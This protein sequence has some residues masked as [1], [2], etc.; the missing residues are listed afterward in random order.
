M[1]P[2]WN[3]TYGSPSRRE[4]ETRLAKE[5]STT[6]L[7]KHLLA[8]AALS[9]GARSEG[10]FVKEQLTKGIRLAAP[11]T[12]GEMA[13]VLPR[14]S[15]HVP[16]EDRQLEDIL[17]AVAKAPKLKTPDI[18]SGRSMIVESKRAPRFE[19]PKAADAVPTTPLSPKRETPTP[20]PSLPVVNALDGYNA[21]AEGTEDKRSIWINKSEHI[22]V[23]AP[24]RELAASGS[25]NPELDVELVRMGDGMFVIV[26]EGTRSLLF[27]VFRVRGN[28]RMILS[29]CF[30]VNS[31]GIDAVAAVRVSKVSQAAVCDATDGRW[32]LRDKGEITV[33]VSLEAGSAAGSSTSRPSRTIPIRH[34]PSSL[35]GVGQLRSRLYPRLDNLVEI[36]ERLP[37]N[38]NQNPEQTKLY[39]SAIAQIIRD[40]QQ[41]C[42][43][44]FGQLPSPAVA[45]AEASNLPLLAD[46]VASSPQTSA[47]LIEY[48]QVASLA[49][50]EQSRFL[51]KPE[52][53]RMTVP[54][55]DLSAGA[56]GD[57]NGY[58][59]LSEMSDGMF[60]LMN[61]DG[62]GVILPVFRIRS[63]QQIVLARYFHVESVG[64][65]GHGS[66]QVISVR[67]PAVCKKRDGRWILVEK[68]EVTIGPRRVS[69]H[70]NDSSP[71]PN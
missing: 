51:M 4:P 33:A 60:I 19:M 7:A 50:S 3:Q 29:H 28:Q 35:V 37:S 18:A 40:V 68:G 43:E 53:R 59:E 24:S 13:R 64:V 54:S 67:K 2:P 9:K 61:E 22:R 20:L 47:V 5:T 6:E 38:P 16:N 26:P 49:E 44:Y 36:I 15:P 42:R 25:Y 52:C 71:T 66:A 11:G 12:L 56:T 48:N 32:M 70:E 27:P 30:K 55:R 58:I 65:K 1:G 17:D 23:T 21:A 57:S 31:D 39:Q 46:P 41:S 8:S 63:G 62:K 34:R 10:N 69:S 45:L 14:Y